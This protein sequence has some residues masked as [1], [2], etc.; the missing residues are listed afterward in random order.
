MAKK[1]A[2]YSAK[3]DTHAEHKHLFGSSGSSD[4]IVNMTPAATHKL[5]GIYSIIAMLLVAIS[6]VPYYVT[7]LFGVGS[8]FMMLRTE[9]NDTTLFLI[10][11]LLLL[12][13]FLGMV[14]FMITCVK[15][16]VVLKRNKALIV[17]AAILV[18]A[19]VSS[20]ISTDMGTSIFGY[21]DRAD[22][23]L[24][25]I[26]Y[27]GFF[28]IGLCLTDADWRRRASNTI[29]G[30]GT[31]NAVL[32]I[33]QSIPALSGWIP[34]YYNYLFLG[35]KVEV[36][37]AEY[38]N[39]YAAYDASYAADGV[40][41]SP[42]AL[43]ALLTLAAAFAVN[44]AA[45][46]DKTPTRIIC[47][48]CTGLM[49]GA[50][51]VTQT[52]P[53]MVGMGCV[54]VITLI[55]AIAS[56]GGKTAIISSALSVA[57]AGC[58]AAGIVLTDN[59]RMSNEQIIFTDS[60][61]RLGIAYDNHTDH[62]DSIYSALLYD[63]WLVFK[64]HPVLGVG[65]DNWSEMYNSGAGM[66]TDRTYNEVF[67]TAIQKGAVG[68]VLYLVMILITFAKAFRVL[69]AACTGKTDR[70]AGIG[71]FTA[72]VSFFI[73]SMLNTTSVCSTPF[74]YLTIGIVW[75]YEA[76]GRLF[77]KKKAEEN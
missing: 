29:I 59:F 65:P 21:L 30:I 53:A 10:M 6:S 28:T 2:T 62:D 73:Q 74:F 19:A 42:F 63:G 25:L 34:S 41:C 47:L 18:A 51:I 71:A 43:G 8:E 58:I 57:A 56:K 61:E 9:N 12:S 68:A 72:F 46:T 50:A 38:F 55:A 33:L 1:S 16:E 20:F 3:S 40:T 22:G 35:Y 15:K 69:K 49:S 64:E 4:F 39:A 17:F 48:V 70:A 32:G 31:V 7:K 23:L 77:P 27:I 60:F 75:S 5:C 13:G 44:K 67:D 54:L 36:Q 37:Y 14:I 66:E 52:L 76:A 24:S 45:Y 26:G 11:T